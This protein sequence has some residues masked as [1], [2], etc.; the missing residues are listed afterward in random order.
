MHPKLSTHSVVIAMGQ[1]CY[2]LQKKKIS[3]M[4][5]MFYNKSR[6][7]II[8]LD[9]KSGLVLVPREGNQQGP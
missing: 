9:M 3:G 1:S 4:L 6:A 2:F 8:Y 7:G 5:N